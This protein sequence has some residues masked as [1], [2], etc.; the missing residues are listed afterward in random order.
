MSENRF[1]EGQEVLAISPI[2][3]PDI[4]TGLYGVEKITVVF[5][6]GQM[7]FVAWFAVWK[8]GEISKKWNPI[9]LEWVKL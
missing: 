3:H 1:E 4:V 6:K 7:D 2:N 5:E 9:Y 8:D